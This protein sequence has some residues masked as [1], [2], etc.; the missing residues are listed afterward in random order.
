MG[1][2][3]ERKPGVPLYQQ[4]KGV[5]IQEIQD[6][7]EE[8][9]MLPIESEIEARY[10]V[11]RVTVR[12]T[13]DELVS[14]GIV[15][16]KQGRGTFV[17]SKEIVQEAG[18]ITSWTEE[19]K[20]KGKIIETKD[21]TISRISPSRSLREKLRVTNKER[22]LC[23]KRIRW[24]D[25]EPIAIMINYIREKYVPDLM[26]RGLSTESLYDVLENEYHLTLEQADEVIRARN[27]S[28]LEASALRIPPEDAVLHISRTSYLSDGAPFEVV[29]MVNRAD[30]YH[31]HISLNGRSKTKML[32]REN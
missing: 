6:H 13:I 2:A 12:R 22:L 3:L 31:Y 27:A 21:L 25:G 16:K 23:L 14:E 28:D 32:G 5:L 26:E 19:M 10:G 17:Q 24:A 4:L 9:D 11:S 7:L 8:G 1:K 30:R 18:T 20:A 15:E 29:E